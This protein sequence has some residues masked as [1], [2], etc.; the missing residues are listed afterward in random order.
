MVLDLEAS[1]SS[2]NAKIEMR[3][4]KSGQVSSLFVC[5]CVC[6]CMSMYVCVCDMSSVADF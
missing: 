4:F 2:E 1:G 6:V 5:V 3:N